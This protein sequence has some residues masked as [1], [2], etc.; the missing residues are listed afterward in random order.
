MASA[1]LRLA[2]K[3]NLE[4]LTRLA[5]DVEVFLEQENAPPACAFSVNLILEEVLTNIVKYTYDDNAVHEI[6]TVLTLVDRRIDITVTDDGHAFN[7]LL[8]KDPDI[9]Q[10]I[11]ERQIGGLG[12]FLVR[13]MSDRAEYRR[14]NDKNVLSLSVSMD[15]KPE[16]L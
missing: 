16:P 8:T 12:L 11:E 7:P 1:S 9:N 10:P 5:R 14:E 2:I 13:K 15:R 4:D 3:N 6:E